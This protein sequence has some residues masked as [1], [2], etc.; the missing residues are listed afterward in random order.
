[1]SMLFQL[2][3]QSITRILHTVLDALY[4]RRC[5]VCDQIVLPKGALICPACFPKSPT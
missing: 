3:F 5:P 2:L 4:P 1:M